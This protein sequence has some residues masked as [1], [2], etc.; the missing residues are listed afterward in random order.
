MSFLLKPR[1]CQCLLLVQASETLSLNV[2]AAVNV[3][4][5]TTESLSKKKAELTDL[6]ASW[7]LHY[8]Q[9]KSVKKQWKKF[10]DQLKK[11]AWKKTLEIVSCKL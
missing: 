7:Q 10:K 5:K 4:E 9:V 2:K 11:V 1:H 8:S 3:V 6:W